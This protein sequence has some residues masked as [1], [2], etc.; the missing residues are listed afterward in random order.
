MIYSTTH[1][2]HPRRPVLLREAPGAVRS[3]S[4]SCAM[5]A[6][7]LVDYRRL[8][9][10]AMVVLRRHGRSCSSRCSRRRL[11]H[12]GPPGVVPAPGRVQLQPSELAKFGIIVALAGYCNQ[13]RGELDA[14]RL[15]VIIGLA[16]SRSGWCC[17]SPTSAPCWCSWSSSW[18]CSP[19]PASAVKQLLVLALLAVTGVY[20]VVEPRAAEAVPDRPAHRRSSTPRAARSQGTAYNQEQSKQAIAHGRLTGEGL[21]RGHA[22]PGRLRARA[23]HRLHLHR[24][25]G[26]SSA[27]SARRRCSRCSPS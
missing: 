9:D 13:Y 7:L 11:E 18:R 1:A 26:R 8:R 21:Q 3:G 6:V 22:D 5:V 2:A 16:A 24:R 14:W 17:S 27:S 4:G 10:H 19:W 25:W 15:T 23:A 12:Q 20:A